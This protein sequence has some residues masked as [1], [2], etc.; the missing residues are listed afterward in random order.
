MSSHPQP[1][2]VSSGRATRRWSSLLSS[3]LSSSSSLLPRAGSPPTAAWPTATNG[4][5]AAAGRWSGKRRGCARQR[6]Q[7]RRGGAMGNSQAGWN[8]HR[9]RLCNLKQVTIAADMCNFQCTPIH[10]HV[11]FQNPNLLLTM[12]HMAYA[13][14]TVSMGCI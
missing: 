9:P 14:Q 1:A 5:G 3:S 8:G 6:R 13:P 2:A 7:S 4:G 10:I 12:A 11:R